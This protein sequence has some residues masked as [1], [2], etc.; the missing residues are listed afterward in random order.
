M[1]DADGINMTDKLD[2]FRAMFDCS[3]KILGGLFL[4][5]NSHSKSFDKNSCDVDALKKIESYKFYIY[6]QALKICYTMN[7]CYQ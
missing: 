1:L 3:H 6:N 2:I 4:F 7:D 5:C